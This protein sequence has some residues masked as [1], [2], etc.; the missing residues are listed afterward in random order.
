[1]AVGGQHGRMAGAGGGWAIEIA[2]D[3]V[4]GD[5]LEGDVLD[6]VAVVSAF[7][8]DDGLQ[9]RAAGPR[10]KLCALLQARAQVGRIALPGGAIREGG[11]GLVEHRFALIGRQKGA[12]AEG[13]AAGRRRWQA[14]RHPASGKPG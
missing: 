14:F 3:E 11:A 1:M 2:G 5:G 9:R 13:G 4:A 10:R 12:L 8:G 6:G 7:R